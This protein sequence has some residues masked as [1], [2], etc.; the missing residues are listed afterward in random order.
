M[1]D[2][3]NAQPGS[4]E[5][6]GYGAEGREQS[7]VAPDPGRGRARPYRPG[8]PNPAGWFPSS[9]GEAAPPDRPREPARSDVPS[10]YAM[11]TRPTSIYR[12]PWQSPRHIPVVG[13]TEALPGPAQALPGPEALPGAAEAVRGRPGRPGVDAPRGAVPGPLDH[14]RKTG[15]QL[16][17]RVWKDSGVTWE[18]P[19][20]QVT[21]GPGTPADPDDPAPYAVESHATDWYPTDPRPTRHDLPVLPMGPWPVQEPASRPAQAP[22]AADSE[23]TPPAPRLPKRMSSAPPLPKRIRRASE[24]WNAA[25]VAT[26]AP[27]G[28]PDELFRAWQG[29]VNQAAGR[30]LPRTARWPALGRDVRFRGRGWQVAK[31]GVP[32][33]V[34]VTVGAGALMMLTGRANGMLAQRASS[35]A[36]S[37][38]KPTSGPVASRQTSV[39]PS[40]AARPGT[41]ASSL[42]LVGYPA[43]HGTVAVAALW[44]AGGATVAVGYADG[45]PAVW[46]HAPDG[47]WSLV[48]TA[49]LG[50]V[51]GHLTSVAQGP[52]GWVAV[53]SVNENGTVEPAVFGSADGVSWQQLTALTAVAG[54]DAQ[55][56]G[57][58]A[59][60]GGYLVVGKQGTGDAASAALWWSSDLQNWV[61]GENNAPPGSHAVAA[62]ATADGFV[63]VGSENN[64]D[65]FWTSSDGQHWTAHDLAEPSGASAAMLTSVAA[66]Q[67]GQADRFVAAGVATTSAGDLPIVVT[68]A[69]DGTHISQV[70]LSSTGDPATVT[71]LTATT[72]GFVAVGA[73][74]PANA[75]HAVTWTSTEGSIWTPAAPLQAAGTSEV[76]AL[77]PTSTPGASATLT[78]TAQVGATP[79]L[80]TFPAP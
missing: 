5:P 43:E 20:A 80:L 9:A 23:P 39:G 27:L 53:G 65:T 35:A 48:S 71:A 8:A 7:R 70:V 37:S 64:S 58:A 69:N 79:T 36:L 72:D 21:P 47:T 62:A 52:S 34:I 56:L 38:G 55:F 26:A 17:L 24:G 75:E 59:G 61:N 67:G 54:N 11:E 14:G 16:A 57:V 78:A 63:A 44:S 15:W 13:P 40:S 31:I 73:A 32:A 2:P 10:P 60:S 30:S 41:S 28:D 46:R 1:T 68:A 50:A 49:V 76:T 33:A 74:G 22:D 18:V 42:A 25:P 45:H 66:G 4:R 3:R 6:S 12:V 51:T 29:S 19:P 77:A